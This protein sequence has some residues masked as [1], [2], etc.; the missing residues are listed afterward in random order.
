MDPKMLKIRQIGPKISKKCVSYCKIVIE[1]KKHGICPQNPTAGPQTYYTRQLK[2]SCRNNLQLCICSQ[3]NDFLSSDPCLV[4]TYASFLTIQNIDF[5]FLR[6]SLRYMISSSSEPDFVSQIFQ[7]PIIGQK[8]FCIQFLH[9]DVSFKEKK[10]HLKFVSWFLRYQ[11][12][13]FWMC[14]T[15][16]VQPVMFFRSW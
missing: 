12:N 11:I 7:P 8:R 3:K 14:Y 10:K 16:Q 13:T 4:Y 2:P 1:D 6:F 15:T 9:M 5:K